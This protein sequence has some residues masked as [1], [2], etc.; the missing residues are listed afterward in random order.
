MS[1]A[2]LNSVGHTSRSSSSP[3][4]LNSW[5][6]QTLIVFTPLI[7]V[8]I[9]FACY[10]P[11]M[12]VKSETIS[13]VVTSFFALGHHLPGMIRAYGD[14]DLF[15]RFHWR[16][17][18][19]PPLLFACFFPLNH[20][21]YEAYRLFTLT[22]A[23]WHGL[24]QLYGFVRIYDMK[25]GSNSIATSYWDWVLCLV[26]FYTPQFISP[27][28]L[29]N[30]LT[31][32]YSIGIPLIPP[33]A[34][35]GFQF[36][37]LL[38]CAVSMIGFLVN[39]AYQHC[40]GKR[41]N[42][43]KLLMLASGIGYWWF[44]T[45]MVKDLL[46]G[47]ALFDI[48]HDVQYLAIVWIYNCRRVSTSP[49]VG[50]FMQLV[51]RRG[52]VMLYLGLIAAYGA[53]GLIPSMSQDETVR[54]LFSGILWT[55]TI[56]HYYMDGFIWKF[57]EPSTRAVMGVVDSANPPTV[58]RFDRSGLMHVMK[59]SP[60]VLILT[61]LFL[62]E[63][64]GS[65][66]SVS[67]A[68]EIKK[69]YS[70]QLLPKKILPEDEKSQQ[71]LYGYYKQLINIAE[72][73]P[74]DTAAQVKA[75]IIQENFGHRAESVAI[76]EKAVSRDPNSASA[77][78]TLGVIEQLSG[79]LDQALELFRKASK[80]ASNSEDRMNSTMKMAEVYVMKKDF[81]AARSLFDEAMKNDPKLFNAVMEQQK[82]KAVQSE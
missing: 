51:F 30:T 2:P 12:G 53:I 69:T 24:M 46:L 48:V 70:Q 5:L 71:F 25:V 45:M 73:V 79:N 78:L 26:W 4:I 22:W 3:W 29:S 18:L 39:Y 64:E 67:K 34:V 82:K 20:Y 55:S 72:A 52:M 10:S 35:Q 17:I 65:S 15:H 31:Y 19:T 33:Q 13:L 9:V 42:P 11:W 27:V 57:R 66:V 75:A 62:P 74:A 63:I 77:Y 1:A 6:D 43:I 59:W 50:R 54:T 44:T 7:V 56:F 36:V 41:P 28:R 60:L 21:H 37:C 23:T 32:C 49:N 68:A 81:A 76:L 40:Y 61:W 58:R 8:P 16:F 80:S 14:R 47:L 38:L